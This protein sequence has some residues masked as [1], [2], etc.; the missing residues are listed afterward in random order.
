MAE[1]LGLQMAIRSLEH[2][3]QYGQQNIHRTL[4]LALGL[5][6]ISNP[7]VF[8]FPALADYSLVGTICLFVF[9]SL[10]LPALV[11]PGITLV[12]SPLVSLIQDQIIH[13]LQVMFALSLTS[14][15]FNT[16]WTIYV[17]LIERYTFFFFELHLGKHTC[18]LLKC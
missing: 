4:P 11:C 15:A 10:Q 3:L 5:L 9:F 18:C 6:C 14:A 2:L 13:L 12:I 17:L 1:E 8:I 16:I 7:K